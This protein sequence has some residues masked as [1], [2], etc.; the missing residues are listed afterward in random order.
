[1]VPFSMSRAMLLVSA[2]TLLGSIGVIM[3]SLVKLRGVVDAETLLSM[4]IPSAVMSAGVVTMMLSQLSVWKV[5]PWMLIGA[6]SSAALLLA[7]AMTLDEEVD[8]GALLLLSEMAVLVL[9]L[10]LLSR[11]MEASIVPLRISDEEEAVA[12]AVEEEEELSLE[13]ML[14]W[15]SV[16][17]S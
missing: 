8:G 14:L 16:S 3:V 6:W 7:S 15:S 10:V 11:N 5:W 12:K 13:V 4:L 17:W 2:L 1:M 9:V